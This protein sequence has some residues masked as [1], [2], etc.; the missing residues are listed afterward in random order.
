MTFNT[1]SVDLT[2]CGAPKVQPPFE[3]TE[4]ATRAD[5]RRATRC[6]NLL[7]MPLPRPEYRAELIGEHH[8]ELDIRIEIGTRFAYYWHV[9]EFDY[10][11]EW[12]ANKAANNAAK[13]GVTFRTAT[14]AVRDP[15]ALTIFDSDQ[16]TPE[17]TRW[18]TTG[19]ASD[20]ICLVVV[21]TWRDLDANSA[22]VRIISA[23]EAT[24]QEQRTYEESI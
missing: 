21:H 8:Q 23:R 12:N 4:Q 20:G 14:D 9:G 18:I 19:R 16:S 13:H 2:A 22:R 1:S 5:F 3:I 10:H 11:F 15:L 6:S 7:A 24:K 17:E